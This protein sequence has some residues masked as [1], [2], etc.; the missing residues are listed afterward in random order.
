[1]KKYEKYLVRMT[2][3]KEIDFRCRGG[4]VDTSIPSPSVHTREQKIKG[5]VCGGGGRRIHN[6]GNF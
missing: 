2:K 6:E 3:K 5:K 1:M 4:P